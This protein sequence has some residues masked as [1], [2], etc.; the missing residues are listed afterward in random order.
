MAL[1]SRDFFM[2]GTHKQFE[3]VLTKYEDALRAKA[4]SKNSKPE[5]L[6]KLD[7]WFHNDLPKKIKSRGKEAHL[8]HD[9]IVQC[10]KWKL[11]MGVFRQK[12]KDLIT[13]NTPRVVMTETKKAFRTL[14][15]RDDLEAA[16][17]SL[18]TMKGV[19]PAFASAVLAAFS[20]DKVPFMSDECLLSMPDCEEVD[21][22]MK[23]YNKMVEEVTRCRTRLNSQGGNWT[24]H[25]IDKAIFSYYILRE[26][27]PDQL[28]DLPD[29]DGAPLNGANGVT[30]HKAEENGDKNGD[31]VQDV[32]EDTRDSVISNNED[33]RD[34]M[35]S[36]NEDTR[37]SVISEVEDKDKVSEEQVETN[38]DT[39]NKPVDDKS[40]ETEKPKS[41]TGE[42]RALES[43]DTEEQSDSKRAREET[44]DDKPGEA[45]EDNS[46]EKNESESPHKANISGQ[47]LV[48]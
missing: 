8:T 39:D 27:K 42:K 28:K 34:S 21:Y 36:G 2:K 4:E 32:D 33:T 14:S 24:L 48:C 45:H 43:D 5:N 13:M 15:K 46:V 18:S 38:G 25:D 22:T 17:S 26:H 3:F 47:L 37:D 12:L 44:N 20:P 23:E 35:I 31:K 9:E 6:V 40:E 19:G 11:S 10:M 7:K 16:I 29:D 1:K 41:P 30:E